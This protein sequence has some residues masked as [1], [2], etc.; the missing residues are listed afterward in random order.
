MPMIIP[1]SGG[2]PKVKKNPKHGMDRWNRWSEMDRKAKKDSTPWMT[3]KDKKL[4]KPWLALKDKKVQNLWPGQKDKENTM[5]RL[6]LKA[7]KD[8]KSRLDGKNPMVWTGDEI[9]EPTRHIGR[10]GP[11]TPEDPK[12]RKDGQKKPMVWTGDEIYK[13]IRPLG[14][15]G[16]VI[17]EDLKPFRL[18]T[19]TKTPYRKPDYDFG[20]VKAT[21]KPE[22]KDDN[23]L[24]PARKTFSTSR[25]NNYRPGR[26]STRPLTIVP[27]TPLQTFT[28]NTITRH[29]SDKV[30]NELTVWGLLSVIV[31]VGIMTCL[32]TA[33]L[34]LMGSLAKAIGRKMGW[35]WVNRLDNAKLARLLDHYERKPNSL[36]QR[37]LDL[38]RI[39]VERH[40]GPPYASRDVDVASM[41][42]TDYA[43]PAGPQAAHLAPSRTCGPFTPYSTGDQKDIEKN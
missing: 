21:E 39:V 27:H 12:P 26:F 38:L 41:Y 2:D 16:P 35:N 14:R 6:E 25:W 9:Y 11:V 10:L 23:Q 34:I 19:T 30:P 22:P 5:P 43:T 33:L 1:E 31:I 15:L 36:D 24:K 8:P 37:N 13:P 29:D 40:E 4:P 17:P 28:R 32:L 18:P 3:L 20:K 42:S 7:K